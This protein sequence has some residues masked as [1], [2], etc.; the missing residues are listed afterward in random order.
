M[1]FSI[2]RPESGDRLPTELA[3]DTTLSWKEEKILGIRGYILVPL[4]NL[5]KDIPSGARKS[6]ATKRED[7]SPLPEVV[8]HGFRHPDGII[9]CLVTSPKYDMVAAQMILNKSLDQFIS[10][11]PRAEWASGT[12]TFN[13]PKM[14][15]EAICTKFKDPSQINKM[16]GIQRDLDETMETLRKAIQQT[17]LRGEQLDQMV[18]KSETLNASSKMFYQQAKK[19][20]SCCVLM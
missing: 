14:D 19:Q 16:A 12:A 10:E 5:A 13:P 6:Q 20:N 15:G 4:R 18:E 8:I 1:Y 7:G 9:G 11:H 2:L 3:Y 17:T